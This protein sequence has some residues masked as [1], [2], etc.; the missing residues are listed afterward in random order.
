MVLDYVKEHAIEGHQFHT[1]PAGTTLS[2]YA[3]VEKLGIE[4]LNFDLR[5]QTTKHHFISF[6]Y[7]KKV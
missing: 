6:K 4:N 7:L 1:S 3:T 5:H 2:S